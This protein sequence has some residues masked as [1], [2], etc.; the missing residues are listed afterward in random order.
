[1]KNPCEN[2]DY[3]EC[4]V[5]VTLWRI[6]SPAFLLIG[7][8]GNALS[9]VILSRQLM[10]GTTTSVYLRLL[11]VVDSLALIV[12]LLR[13]MISHYFSFDVRDLT[14]LSCKL[15]SWL[16]YSTTGLSCWLLSVIAIDRLI[17]IKY[18]LWAKTHCTRTLA[19]IVAVAVIVVVMLLNSHL[20]WILNKDEIQFYSNF[21]NTTVILEVTCQA[22]SLQFVV[23]WD[24]IWPI[25]VLALY[26]FLP[27]TCLITCNVILLCKLSKRNKKFP[28]S[29]KGKGGK[30]QS[31]G[32]LRSITI[33]LIAVCLFF[34]IVTLPVCV[35]IITLPFLY[36]S[37]PQGIARQT[38]AWAFTVF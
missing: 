34:I 13:E 21:S 23:F 18:P 35:Y 36:T 22:T 27:I 15:Q 12:S 7:L 6:F 32:D 29:T 24:R 11:A 5:A 28:S 4:H 20:L 17:S 3:S 10:C 16:M 8:T 33:M 31:I 1:M 2:Q 25:C 26:S 19:L 9:V 37:T 14:D 38:L 30:A